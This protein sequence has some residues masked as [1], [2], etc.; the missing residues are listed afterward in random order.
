MSRRLHVPTLAWMIVP[1]L[2]IVAATAMAEDCNNNGIDDAVDISSGTSQDCNTNGVPDECELITE[3]KVNA[4]DGATDDY[5]GVSVS[6][7]GNVAVI[8]VPG[9]DPVDSAYVFR[10]NGAA[11]IEEAKLVASDATADDT[12]GASVAISDDV[13]VIGAK[14][15]DDHGNRS[16]SAY[17][18][19]WNGSTWI[20][21][22]KLTASDA[23]ADDFFGSAVT[24]NEDVAII[25]ATEGYSEHGTAYVFRW[26]GA[27][28]IEEA[29]LTASDRAR[30]DYFGCSV[31]VSDN[32]AII[33]AYGN[34]DAGSY[35]GSAYIFQWDGSAWTEQV[36]LTASDGA[37]EDRFGKSVSTSGDVVIIG[38]PEDD[39]AGS[40]SGSVYVFVGNGFVWSQ[41]DKLTATDGAVNDYFGRSVSIDGNAAAIGTYGCDPNG[42]AY[43][44]HWDGSA[45]IEYA[46]VTA[47][48][49]APSDRFGWTA[50]ISSNTMLVAASDDDSKGSAYLFSWDSTDCDTNG[51]PDE[52]ESQ[53]DCNNN[54]VQDICDIASGTSADCNAND[55]PD[56]CDIS[57]GTSQDLDT[58]G[59]PDECED[60]N[61]NGIDDAIDIASGTS[62][63][64]NTN[65]TPDECE[66]GIPYITNIT[67]GQAYCVIQDAI[68]NANNGEELVLAAGTYAGNGNR[69]LNFGGKAIT[70]RG[71]DPNDPGV[72]AATVID[73]EGTESEHHRGFNFHSSENSSSVV[74]GLTITN[75]LAAMGGGISCENSSPS[76]LSCVITANQAAP[77]LIGVSDPADARGGNGGGIYC[78]AASPIIHSCTITYN[79]AGQGGFIT[80]G[81]GGDGGHGGGLYCE[82]SSP[83]I[84]N[85]T[86][87]NNHAGRGMQATGMGTGGDAGDGGGIY[88]DSSSSVG[89]RGCLFANNAAGDGGGSD[90]GLAKS[91]GDGGGIYCSSAFATIVNTT[92]YGNRVGSGGGRL[93]FPDAP[94][95]RGGGIRRTNLGAIINNAVIWANT[96]DQMYNPSACDN[97]TFS[98]IGDGLCAGSE[99]VISLD[100]VFVDPNGPDANPNTWEDN[101]YHLQSTSPC[102][103]AGDPN[104]V[105]E[106]GETDIDG[107]PRVQQCRV[108]MGSDET[109]DIGVGPDCQTNGIAD[110]CDIETGTSTDSNS[111]GIPDECERAVLTSAVSRKTH[112]GAGNWD[113]DV[114]IGD[115]ESRSAQLGTA[116]PNELLIVATFD[117][118][119]TLLGNPD[120][121]TT[122]VGT[123]SS[124]VPGA[125]NNE[126]EI[127]ITDLTLNTQINLGF[128]GVVDAGSPAP[129]PA[130]V[131][132]LCVRV[133][134]GD[135]DNLGRTNFTD[136]ALV[137]NAGYINQLVNTLDKARADFDCSGRPNFTD[138][139]KVK[140]A[141]LINQTAPACPVPPIGP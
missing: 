14:Y 57:S 66:T 96:P 137:K 131:S 110:A 18:F 116:N 70:V 107:E 75:G 135:Y 36:K 7:S 89:I 128:G 51:I 104:F 92:L 19:R 61:G 24:I 54:S 77:G 42:A 125:T 9:D 53:D 11:W 80:G 84:E 17:V 109:D 79:D 55:I 117:A 69:D 108:D 1:V 78:L 74:S 29:Q 44:F 15:D 105:P 25:G 88:A 16:G 121:V 85:C 91:G 23:G 68:D 10:W 21:E 126:L 34:D 118:D 38:A 31:S 39:D 40:K 28:W 41:Q 72:V 103:N 101:D 140:N 59:I 50:A 65:F 13:A 52:C 95:G 30:K 27:A 99:G 129:A 134:V 60:C 6:I 112:T 100:P 127:A 22:A 133:I 81:D 67:T 26:N 122:D 86:F 139:A 58:D 63:D 20:E 115:I 64:C 94:D 35:S 132:T 102:I 119:V 8:G 37:A 114:G 46:K 2:C 43:V 123:V 32:K 113:I 62:A 47:S 82:S 130:C 141:G 106:A 90:Y 73:C 98:N 33:G 45:W 12:F 56:E 136:F 97:V 83:T 76:I 3:F 124:V 93:E 4:S 138:F 5:F 49:G 111:N 71:T 87:A 120:D 48:D